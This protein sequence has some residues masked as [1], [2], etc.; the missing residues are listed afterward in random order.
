MTCVVSPVDFTT[1]VQAE[2][3]PR[4]PLVLSPTGL[5]TKAQFVTAITVVAQAWH[6]R[7]IQAARYPREATGAHPSDSHADAWLDELEREVPDR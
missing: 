5:A 3:A 4:L 6:E 2:S 7:Q 1:G